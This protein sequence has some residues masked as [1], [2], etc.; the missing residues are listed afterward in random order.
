MKVTYLCFA[1]VSRLLELCDVSY[2][3]VLTQAQHQLGSSTFIPAKPYISYKGRWLDKEHII[4]TQVHPTQ[5]MQVN[6]QAL[7]GRLRQTTVE[8][9]TPVIMQCIYGR[10]RVLIL[11]T[12]FQLKH[13]TLQTGH[14]WHCGRKSRNGGRGGRKAVKTTTTTTTKK[15]FLDSAISPLCSLS[16][17]I[18]R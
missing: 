18:T 9:I 7:H 6:L 8:M 14:L 3:Q 12:D 5:P 2:R 4:P 15:I 10:V 1:V 17:I 11:M 16:S 13:F